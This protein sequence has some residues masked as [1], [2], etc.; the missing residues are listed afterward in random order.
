MCMYM[1]LAAALA[2]YVCSHCSL[3]T[4]AALVLQSGSASLC[5]SSGHTVLVRASVTV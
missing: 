5:K 3:L 2:A 1:L 4:V